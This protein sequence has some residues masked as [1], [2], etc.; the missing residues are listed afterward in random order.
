ML[1]VSPVFKALTCL[2]TISIPYTGPCTA[3]VRHN[4]TL[5]PGCSLRWADK[6]SSIR[7]SLD[8][9]TAAAAVASCSLHFLGFKSFPTTSRHVASVITLLLS[10]LVPNVQVYHLTAGAVSNTDPAI[11][12]L[13]TGL[14]TFHVVII[15]G[16]FMKSR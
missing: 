7:C 1:T 3:L 6:A 13:L 16:H 11:V 15:I 10:S 8:S 2:G 9:W 14:A 5:Y 12:W 4:A